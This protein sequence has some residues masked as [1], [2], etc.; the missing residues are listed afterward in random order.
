MAILTARERDHVAEGTTS[1]LMISAA[2]LVC[3]QWACQHVWEGARPFFIKTE[4]EQNK[5]E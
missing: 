1:R 4:T 3:I 2:F 5:K